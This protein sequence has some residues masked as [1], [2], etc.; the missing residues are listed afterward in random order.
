MGVMADVEGGRLIRVLAISG[1]LRRA[2]SNTALVEAAARLAPAGVEVSIYR[3]LDRIPPFNPDVDEETTEPVLG[4]RR[5]L[6]SSDAVVI[7]S[8]E[9]AHGVSGVLKN[10][11]DWIVG[12][13]DLIGKPIGLI[14]TSGRAIHAHAALKE[15]LTT[16]SARVVEEASIVIPLDGK[17]WNA[18]GI[19]G[20]A[21]SA[22]ALTA[23]IAALTRAI[24][25]ET[26][27]L[28]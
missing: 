15:T 18:S 2:S 8:P 14:N 23:A 19:A 24:R 11:L 22:A 7:S 5:A 13:G 16:M 10:A 1:S 9:Y 20:D 4:F 28:L 17:T 12:S 3:E 26:T 21:D 27:P 25:S 6:G